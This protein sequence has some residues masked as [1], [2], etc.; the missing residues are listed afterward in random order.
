MILKNLLTNTYYISPEIIILFGIFV[1]TLTGV[2]I[3][4]NSVGTTCNLVILT[5]IISV[6][7][8]LSIGQGQHLLFNN[9]VIISEFTQFSKGVILL[10]NCVILIMFHYFGYKS[11][12]KSAPFEIPIIV[13]LATLGMCIFVS[14]NSLL[15]F[16]LGLELFSL[17]IYI[18]IATNKNDGKSIEASLKYFILGAI[19]SGIFLFGASLIYGNA[20]TINFDEISFVYLTNYCTNFCFD[21][22]NLVLL[23]G[24][25]LLVITVMFKLSLFPF[26]NWTP[27]VYEGSPTS[28]T[29]LLASSAK[30]AALVIFL[31]LVFEP[32]IIIK[33]QLQQ[34]LII[35]SILSILFGNII[36]LVQVNIKRLIAY[37]AIGNMGFILMSVVSYNKSYLEY[38]IF[39]A[40]TYMI[41][42]LTFFALIIVLNRKANF[43]YKL[44]ELKGMYKNNAFICF[45]LA[46]ILF[47]MAGIPPLAGFWA[48][49]Y[50]FIILIKSKTYYLAIIAFIATV[51]GAVYY[52]NVIRKMYFDKEQND[53]IPP[54]IR[55]N[56]IE[57][58][59]IS[60]GVAFNIL[61]VLFPSY[62]LKI[63]SHYV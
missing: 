53:I 22:Q 49:F 7:Q 21:S 15:S 2:F 45:S 19:S 41:Q 6:Y 26:H 3:K 52:I 13:A 8:I 16:Y 23:T 12:N 5:F 1:A 35:I 40:I 9:S 39:Y 11:T 32:L 62:M 47:S 20:G 44:E 24:F 61:Y 57:I 36:A 18:L 10:C 28:I 51:I 38:T 60:L 56:I 27:D 50:I 46:V 55:L 58:L 34:I 31:R 29:A 17:A 48:K 37:S 4:K 33:E 43:H 30:F 54:K 59:I 25:I 14:S 42:I 63:I